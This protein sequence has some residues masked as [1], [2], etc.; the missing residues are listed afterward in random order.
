MD[1]PSK[2]SLLNVDLPWSIGNFSK[3]SFVRIGLTLKSLQDMSDLVSVINF[4]FSEF[5]V[6]VIKFTFPFLI[7]KS[8]SGRICHY[9]I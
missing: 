7:I 8:E 5:E 1:N 6:S 9:V 3:S 2:R 4:H